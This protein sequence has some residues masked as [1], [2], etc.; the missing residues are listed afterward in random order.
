MKKILIA[1]ALILLV[2]G[3]AWGADVTCYVSSQGSNTSPYDTWAKAAT[4]INAALVYM[5]VQT[6]TSGHR[7]YIAPGTYTGDSLDL[8]DVD[9]AGAVITGTDAH[10][11]TAQGDIGDV[12]VVNETTWPII[13]G[14]A[15][16]GY[17]V[18]VLSVGAKAIGAN[19]N[20][21]FYTLSGGATGIL[22]DKLWTV[23]SVTGWR[24][25]CTGVTITRSIF[26]GQVGGTIDAVTVDHPAAFRQVTI[27]NSAANGIGK[28]DGYAIK[29]VHTTGT[30]TIYNSVVRGVNYHGIGIT[31]SGGTIQIRNSFVK[32]CDINGAGVPL[33]A[34]TG[35]TLDYDYNTVLNG[36]DDPDG[37]VTSGAGTFTDGGNNFLSSTPN[38]GK[39]GF[40]RR[41]RSGF[42]VPVIDDAV[43][44][45]TGIG[46]Y[47][48]LVAAVWASYGVKGTWAI[49]EVGF[50]AHTD[51]V[52]AILQK[53]SSFSS[54]APTG[55]IEPASHQNNN[56]SIASTGAAFDGGIVHATADVTVDRATDTITVDGVG[57]VTGF[58]AKRLSAIKTELEALA[59]TVGTAFNA[60][61]LGESMADI[62]PAAS[63]DPQILI[64]ATGATGLLKAEITTPKTSIASKLSTA[65]GTTVN[66]Y[67]LSTAG[68]A[69]SAEAVAAAKAAGFWGMRTANKN[70]AGI[71]LADIDVFNL[72]YDSTYG[73]SPGEPSTET[74]VKTYTRTWAEFIAQQGGILFILAHQVSEI[75]VDEWG[76]ILE[77]L[78]EEYPEITVTS[79]Y[80]ALNTIRSGGDWADDGDGTYSR[81][82][83]DLSDSQ[84]LSD[85][86][87]INAGTT[88]ATVDF[89]ETQTDYFG[90][91]YFFAPYD[92]LNI[93][94]D[95]RYSDAANRPTSGG[96]LW[97]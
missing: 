71:L 56:V 88:A 86:S 24:I 13:I 6:P 82:W 47:V 32:G 63:V 10:G 53:H 61:A 84:L 59:C 89:T 41:Q 7:L 38:V 23:D 77:V 90:N 20:P 30:T 22:V 52:T 54:G 49:D 4:T 66:L 42:I 91:E 57:S 50:D 72:Y 5:R 87:L 15:G 60:N 16:A 81:T 64:D 40:T 67:S 95:Q 43:R 17:G 45:G 37:A 19:T 93:G 51:G 3:Q 69:Y 31:G 21:T 92:R 8:R 11:S 27:E 28:T 75:S 85:S 79:M 73:L 44:G 58:K 36:W 39:I 35:A 83:T 94:A 18:T 76:W 48:D 97:R 78:T 55:T 9:F 70:M 12:L 25:N 34:G 74:A 46:S 26:Q 14:N 65:L 1:A 80:D 29:A 68:G 62:G 96:V 33:V 2:A